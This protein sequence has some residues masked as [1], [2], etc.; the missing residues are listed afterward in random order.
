MQLFQKLFAI[1][2][3]VLFLSANCGHAE[4]VF[5]SDNF[6]TNAG[7]RWTANNVWHI[8]S[9]TAGPSTNAA[10]FRT[11]S[12]SHCATT[13][14]YPA[15]QDARLICTNYNGTNF[16]VVPAAS[17][18]PRLRF[19]QWFNFPIDQYGP[20]AL[21]FVELR[22]G[23]NSWQ[24]ISPTYE[25]NGGDVWSRPAIDLSSFAG[26]S[27]QIAF[28]FNC[29]CCGNALGWYVDDVAVVTSAP[30]FNNPES[31]EAGLGDW[32][33]PAGTWE[34]G[35][36]TSGPNMAHA[37][38]NCAGTVLAGNYGWNLDTRLIS[39][40]FSLPA[41]T[42]SVLRFWHWYSFLNAAGLVEIS[43]GAANS[44]ATTNTTITTN[45]V[46]S[47][48][49]NLYQFVGATFNGYTNFYWNQ[50]IGGWTN[51][52]KA[53]GNIPDFD[54]Y[55]FE[56]GNVPFSSIGLFNYFNFNCDYRATL[57]P[58][59]QSAAA[60]NYLSLHGLTW[61]NTTGPNSPVGYFGTNYNATYTTNIT[62]VY[63]TNNWQPLSSVYRSVGGAG[64]SSGGWTNAVF[65][66]SAYAG[67]SI[68]IAFHFQSGGS[69]YGNAAGW[70]VDDISIG[71]TNITTSPTLLALTNFFSG[72]KF[73]FDFTTQS[74]TT[75]R[76]E[77]STNLSTWK[78]VFTNSA[79]DGVFQFTDAAAT[80]FP[81][82]FYRAVSQ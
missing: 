55:H 13:Q 18:N 71:S 3:T 44:S 2:C 61:T 29:G 14:N 23:T 70:Y 65:D 7:S 33:V 57:L 21:G 37:G 4:T 30:I 64:A 10:G 82:R 34:V 9:P 35:K 31:F 68:Q 79:P 28:R 48:N 24:Q 56:A 5:W 20:Y 15:N 19:W 36:P 59:P 74:N 69:G 32:A 38:T 17:Q 63:T 39:P 60:T 72:K 66:L 78:P 26:Q 51:A 52:T 76:V 43:T 42:N 73:Q 80:N 62:V 16:L 46:T 40:P 81:R 75:W 45:I 41:G 77:A 53:L 54:G 27:V 8:A 11:Y 50:T 22:V 1:G 12:A 58:K 67:K 47:L 6:E 25:S 49:T